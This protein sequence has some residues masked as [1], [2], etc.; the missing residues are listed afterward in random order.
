MLIINYESPDGLKRHNRLWNGGN[1]TATIKLYKREHGKEVL[2]DEIA[3]KNVG[4]KYGE[5]DPLPG[6]RPVKK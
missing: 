5:Y 4:C 6:E 2:I 1:G 3:A